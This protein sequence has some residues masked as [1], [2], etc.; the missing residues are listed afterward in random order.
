[1]HAPMSAAPMG[2]SFEG[3]VVSASALDTS[4]Q[5][6][7]KWEGDPGISIFAWLV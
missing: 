2:A 1:M 5:R 6:P 3:D 4:P 7:R